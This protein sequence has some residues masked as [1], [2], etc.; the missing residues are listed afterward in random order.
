MV[1]T[2]EARR[3]A[4]TE[5][6]DLVEISPGTRP[7]V[8][9][10]M[11]YGKHAFE[12]A[13]KARVARKNQKQSETKEIQMRPN[14]GEHDFQIKMNHAKEFLDRGD[15]V[16]L[17]LKYRGREITHAEIG[18]ALMQSA[19]ETLAEHGLP[20]SRPS[21]EGKVLS[22]LL[23]P[24]PRQHSGKPKDEAAKPI[25]ASSEQPRSEKARIA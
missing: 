25:E 7:P 15:R 4:E 13:K 3:L 9:R 22:V 20:Q 10:I 24:K 12:E 8:C 19:L 5:G 23:A 16:S 14:I 21:L 18:R 17:V 1:D 6:L 11:D 2:N